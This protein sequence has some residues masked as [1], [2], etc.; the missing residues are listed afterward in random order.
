MRKVL[1]TLISIII[2]I[3]FYSCLKD[4]SSTK[5][6]DLN[7]VSI[8]GIPDTI[9][10]S[11]GDALKINPIL[12]TPNVANTTY[13]YLWYA[14]TT[15]MQFAA[16]TL[17]KEKNLNAQIELLPGTYSLVFRIMDNSNKI[18]YKRTV[19]MIVVNDYTPGIMI[20][21]ESDGKADLNF[22][23]TAT[24]K[25]ITDVYKKSNE[26]E[27]LGSN[28]VS[29]SYYAKN[30][31]M[32]AEV[33]ILCKDQR[34]GV[35]VD[36]VTF[37]KTRDL[38]NS[39]YVP[40]SNSGNINVSKYVK[41][42]G[43]LQDYVIID[44]QPYNRAVNSGD[45][46]FK[47]ALLANGNYFVSN[48]VFMEDYSSRP[49]F[50]DTVGKRFLAHNNTQGSLN[51]L[52]Q[53]GTNII[54]PKN[55]GLDLLYAGGVSSIEFFGLFK[56]PGTQEYY[57]LDMSMNGLSLVFQAQTKYVMNGADI[58]KAT[59]FASSPSLTNYLFYAAGSKC[60][61]YNILSKS[62]G[63]L[64]D[65]G[66]NY[67][68]NLLKMDNTELKIAF[69]NNAMGTKKAGFATFNISTDGGIQATETRR[70]EGVMD[71]IVDLTNK[72]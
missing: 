11:I 15:N 21:G 42:G 44:G 7:E 64:F 25:Y 4:N 20:L 3:S 65:L 37:Q 55:V 1:L 53:N 60:Y 28:P 45:L 34:G 39:F 6:F 22:L 27:E 29:I 57:I 69:T 47:P 63:F 58:E 5:S 26:N 52:T 48:Q 41:K 14:Y 38:K 18:F 24:G 72:Q 70:K 30:Y 40:L 17:S 33:L 13:E 66:T 12:A 31:S 23:N 67:N 9:T 16:D 2:T 59:A 36:P 68:I 61:V 35:F 10:A 49:I 50:Y 71:K 51:T 56:T 62:G 8:S 32:P 54:D 19:T 46:L 43:N